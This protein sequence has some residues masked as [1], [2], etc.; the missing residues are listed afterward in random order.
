MNIS[1][2]E[3]KPTIVFKAF[4]LPSGE[5]TLLPEGIDLTFPERITVQVDQVHSVVEIPWSK[6]YLHYIDSEWQP[7]FK[8]VL[9]YLRKRTTNV[10]TARCFPFIDELIRDTNEPVNKDV[11]KTAFILHDCGWSALT[12]EEIAKSFGVTGLAL[13]EKSIGP[14]E[15]HAVLGQEIAENILSRSKNIPPLS[16]DQKEVVLKAI[17]Y[18]DKPTEVNSSTN[19]PKEVAIVCD[20]DHLWSFTFENFWQDTIRKGIRPDVYAKNLARDMKDYFI[21]EAGI[22]KARK[23]LEKR[24]EEV[25]EWKKTTAMSSQQEARKRRM[26]AQI[27]KKLEERSMH[28]AAQ[29]HAQYEKE[30][31]QPP[32]DLRMVLPRGK[33]FEVASLKHHKKHIKRLN[34]E[35]EDL[36][37]G[38]PVE[39]PIQRRRFR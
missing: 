28:Y 24:L 39:K 4:S 1:E 25:E 37:E 6:K 23:L 15:K 38:R 17:K 16:K 31:E 7:F 18:H 20:V 3:S 5:T 12:D 32:Y 11:I 14:K 9:P 19:I 8:E 26:N 2:I 33:R 13:N 34:K 29:E 21:T 30:G 35:I 10:H 22:N 36:K 27:V